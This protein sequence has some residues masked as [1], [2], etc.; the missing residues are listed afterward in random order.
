MEKYMSTIKVDTIS[1]LIESAVIDVSDIATK[2]VDIASKVS[3]SSLSA[4]SGASLVGYLPAGTAGAVATTVQ[5]KLRESVSVK[6]FGAVGDGV[7]DD[8]VAIELVKATGKTVYFPDGNYVVTGIMEMPLR[9]EGNFTITGNIRWSTKNKARQSGILFV[10]GTVS[11]SG[12]YYS[13]FDYI[14]CA[15]YD[16]TLDGNS[17]PWGT[18]WNKFGFIRCNTLFLNVDQGQSVNQNIFGTVRAAVHIKG[19][20]TSGIREAHNNL[21]QNLDTTG[22]DL[23]AADGTT[24]CHLLND[25]NL[26]Q[27]N[28]VI[29]WYAESS[30]S[31]R[32]YG[33]WNILGSNVDATNNPYFI[34]RR[35]SALFSGGTG[36][37]GSFFAASENI[38][39]GGDWS[40]LTT[41]GIPIVLAGAS[42]TPVATTN[43]PDGNTLGAKQVGGV[44]FRAIDIKYPLGTSNTVRAA[45]FV[46]QE[47]TPASSIEILDAS[48]SLVMSAAGSYTPLGGGWYL[49]R[50]AGTSATGAGGTE[51]R[52]RIYTTT[53]S[54]LTAADFRVL[55]SFFVTTDETVML[56]RVKLG[57]KEG[58]GTTAPTAGTWA[59]GD[60]CWH[61]APAAAGVPGWVCTT[62]GSPGTWK[63]MAALAA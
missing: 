16:L 20:N 23:T 28:N 49:L 61:T 31:R 1:D 8:T 33:N 29:N 62:A 43:A 46:Y 25:S 40:E 60:R 12:V 58:F 57:P 35:N 44:T 41:S 3:S 38:S 15:G 27:C 36:R 53:S 13:E 22:A 24:G 54:A 5:T 9:C 10:V 6:D 37:N 19:V 14:D 47:G 4:S 42:V 11:I 55:G 7:T 2:S 63:A 17:A 30:G 34:G 48:L 21:I 39:R 45:A 52:I 51:G 59:L 56:P 18:F 50:V 32:A 26:N